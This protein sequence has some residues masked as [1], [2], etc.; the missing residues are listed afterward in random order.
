TRPGAVVERQEEVERAAL[1]ERGGELQ[2]LELEEQPAADDLG[3]RLC[4]E[5]WR[6]RDMLADGLMREPD[7][8]RRHGGDCLGQR[9]GVGGRIGHSIAPPVAGAASLRTVCRRLEV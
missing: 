7:R 4:L 9:G 5:A 6:Q 8:R 1:L 2:V 3:E